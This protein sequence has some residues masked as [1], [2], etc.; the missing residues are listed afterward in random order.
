MDKAES[1]KNGQNDQEIDNYIIREMILT[2]Y[3]YQ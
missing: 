3:L 1:Q 2:E